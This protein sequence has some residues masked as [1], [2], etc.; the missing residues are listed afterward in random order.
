MDF[1]DPQKQK[2]HRIRL[3]IGYVLVG[4]LVIVATIILLYQTYGF[5]IN[6]SG[7]V[8]QSGL[9]F[10]S[11]QPSN[12]TIFLNGVEKAQT[13][14]RLNLPAGQYTVK[15]QRDGY[16]TWQRSI[17]VEGGS[18]ERFD[19]PLLLPVKLKTATIAKYT[20]K[21][22]VMLQSPDQR[23]LLIP[24]EATFGVFDEYDLAHPKNAVQALSLPTG[25]LSQS[26][27][28]Q[29]WQLSAWS[30][31]NTHALLK[32]AFTVNGQTTSEYILLNR[33]NPSAS[34]NLTKTLGVNPDNIVLRNNAYDQYYLYDKAAQTLSTASL[35]A[36]TPVAL[37]QHVLAFAASGNDSVL[38]I[39]GASATNTASG[40]GK[41][42]VKLR[43]SGT[44][45]TIGHVTASTSY[46][47]NLAQYK[48]DWYVAYGA[49]SD[50]KI[51]VYKNPAS[52]VTSANVIVPSAVLKVTVPS[53]LSFSRADQFLMAESGG[54]FAVFDAQND[55]T[56]AY[57]LKPP[58]DAPQPNATWIDDYHLQYISGGKD[59]LFDFDSANRQTLIAA[60][61]SIAP[62]FDAKYHT[63]YAI[64]PQITPA[65]LTAV[66][67]YALTSTSMLT[68]A[69]Q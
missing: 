54:N 33:D 7:Q 59:L 47:L 8:I 52:Q 17:G 69:D 57:T 45:Y 24:N 44:T 40:T 25:S 19:Y 6:S 32:H 35:S 36:S 14:A 27:G 37:A 49:T 56:Y 55:K 53:V 43:Q 64:A 28:P 3:L 21:P 41:V 16:R 68:P 18:I 34:I 66:T 12:A 60:D 67:G 51:D 9:V 20:A 1:L 31:D 63:L 50:N 48:N 26:T 58:L 38:Y 22:D 2:A 10:V 23:W 15:V 30:S 65:T 62:V 46:I 13:N 4:L 42:A 5:G 39:D 61:P 29:N 11:S